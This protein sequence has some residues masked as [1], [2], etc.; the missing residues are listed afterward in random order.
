MTERTFVSATSGPIVLGLSLPVGSVRV[1]VLNN[2]TTARVTLRTDDSTGPAADA[3]NRTRGE[4][5][6]QV[7][8]IEVPD[9]PDGVIVRGN[10]GTTVMHSVGSVN[11]VGGT[12]R[13]NG[14]VVSGGRG[15]MS[16]VSPIEVVVCLPAGS[17]FGLVGTSADA[18]VFGYID[19]MEFRSVSGDLDADGVRQLTANTT[20]GDINVGRIT[21]RITAHAVSGD[22]EVRL[23]DG[24]AATLNTTSGDIELQATDAAS[25]RVS[26]H[27]VSGDVRLSGAHHLSVSADSVSGRLRR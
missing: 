17:S 2:L 3:V 9:M 18:E 5:N 13:I 4:Q 10:R 20:S 26:A 14:R 27:S 21:E 7:L 23:Y 12:V 11:V 16:T 15:N 6:G 25:G 19:R 8:G 22:I 1:Q 24:S